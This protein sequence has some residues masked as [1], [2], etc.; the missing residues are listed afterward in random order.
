MDLEI[1]KQRL[2]RELVATDN[3]SILEKTV[4]KMFKNGLTSSEIGNMLNE[5]ESQN[6]IRR[7]SFHNK[8]YIHLVN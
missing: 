5:L 8:N 7:S 2:Q 4:Y 1:A 6:F 3:H